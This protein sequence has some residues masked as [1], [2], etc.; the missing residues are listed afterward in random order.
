MDS[1][2]FNALANEIIDVVTA[3]PEWIHETMEIIDAIRDMADTHPAFAVGRSRAGLLGELCDM[4]EAGVRPALSCLVDGHTDLYGHRVAADGLAIV[5]IRG[6][7]EYT[8]PPF[9]VED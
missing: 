4:I 7:G 1:A 5:P 3:E 2:K 9:P 6:T 8:P